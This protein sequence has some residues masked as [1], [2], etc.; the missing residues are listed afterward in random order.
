LVELTATDDDKLFRPGQMLRANRLEQYRDIEN[1]EWKFLM[2]DKSQDGPK[3]PMGS[4]GFRWGKEQGKWNLTLQDGLTGSDIDPELSFIECTEETVQVSLDDFGQADEVCRSVP[5]KRIK[6]HS[7]EEVILTTAYDLLMAQYGVPRG[8]AGDKPLSYDDD[9]PY[10]PA[11]SEKYTGMSRDMVIR[12]AREWART[13]ELTKG[14]CTIIIGAGINHWYHGNL[15][16]RA[17]INALMFCGCVGVNGGGL[18]HYVGQEKLAPGESWTS[19]ALAKDWYPPSRLQNA[20]SW[21]YVH[22]DQW[23]YEKE[24]TDYHT[25]PRHQPKDTLAHGH[26]MDIQ[27]RAVRSGWLP[28]YPQFNKNPLDVVKDARAEGAQTSDDV[29]K[30]VVEQLKSGKL[31]F[32]VEDP[33]APENWPRIWYIWRG[34]ALMSSSKGHE[35]F[36]KHYLGTHT[37]TIAEDLAEESVQEIEWHKSIQTSFFRPLPG[38]RK[39]TSIR[40]ICTALFILFR[41]RC[42]HAGNPAVTGRYSRTSP[43]NFPN[44]PQNIFQIR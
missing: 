17:G 30:S 16:Y 28:F 31:K 11:W 24:F 3:M 22:T 44:W 19:I 1:G 14:K 5:V 36:L 23:R 29:A 38:M 40:P 13:A 32:S 33:D 10:T 27:S 15:M 37:N 42:R 39:L 25:V 2:W 12:F 7:G 6:T 21:H 34:N 9:A 43:G 41:R 35:Y 26:T 18:A 4:V 20:P 8:L